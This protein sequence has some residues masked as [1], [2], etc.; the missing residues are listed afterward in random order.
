MQFYQVS[1]DW[2]YSPMLNRIEN[3]YGLAGIGFYW[4]VVCATF[5]AGHALP[6]FHL[7]TLKGK[8]LKWG[9]AQE[10]LREYPLF[11]KSAEGNLKIVKD[12]KESGVITPQGNFPELTDIFGSPACTHEPTQAPTPE[13]R[14]EGMP[15]PTLAPTPPGSAPVL[16]DSKENIRLEESVVAEQ[17][18]E[19]A[20]EIFLQNECPHL[21]SF[22]E[23]ITFD[24][25]KDLR[26]LYSIEDIR[27]VL[28]DMND[29]PGL[30]QTSRSC[31]KT[32]RRWLEARERKRERRGI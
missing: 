32:A 16:V 1:S 14:P 17:A 4:K 2:I 27:S 24:E 12:L 18:A 11:V 20:F 13:H 25:L 22:E 15:A 5:L 26:E 19:E 31:A 23:P 6:E 21:Y 8:G 28:V 30:T 3:R 29:R 7:L 10:I 9:E